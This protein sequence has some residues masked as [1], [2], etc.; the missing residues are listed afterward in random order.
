MMGMRDSY[1]LPIA[2]PPTRVPRHAGRRVW[3]PGP[4]R[5]PSPSF[6]IDTLMH[7]ENAKSSWPSL[8]LI[9]LALGLF[10]VSGCHDGPMYGLKA[11]NPYYSMRE[12]KKD[13]ELG[14]TDHVRRVE[15]TKLAKNMSS[16]PQDRQEYWFDHLRK[17]MEHDQNPEMRRLAVIAAG[18]SAVPNSSELLREGLKDSSLKV[19]LAACE[20]LGQRDDS[21]ST[22]LLADTAGGTTDLDVRNAAYAALGKHKSKIAVDTLRLAL[23]DR[24]PATRSLAVRSLRGSTGKNYGDDPQTWIAALDGQDVPEQPTQLA[25]RLKGLIR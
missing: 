25:E 6:P 14:I 19:R 24:D 15:L 1:Q 9:A 2:T 11:A 12:W 3:R 5:A 22:R 10:G 7:S 13:E 8:R 17:V 20:M 16:L 4:G 21:E 23:D 18:G